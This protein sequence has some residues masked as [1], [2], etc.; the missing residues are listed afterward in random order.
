MFIATL[1]GIRTV[2]TR[3]LDLLAFNTLKVGL[4]RGYVGRK[5]RRRIRV[6]H[7]WRRI[8]IDVRGCWVWCAIWFR[9]TGIIVDWERLRVGTVW[10]EWW[11]VMFL[12]HRTSILGL[13][14][15]HLGQG[16]CPA[17]H[18]EACSLCVS[19]YARTPLELLSFPIVAAQNTSPRLRCLNY[20]I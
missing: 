13:I 19:V 3:H 5:S 8:V 16:Y 7:A 1:A 2:S 9:M 20:W 18:V 15:C 11:H 14:A 6:H 17:L 12:G 4:G 10:L